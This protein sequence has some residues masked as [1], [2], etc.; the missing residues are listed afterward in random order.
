MPENENAGERIKKTLIE[1]LL[2]ETLGNLSTRLFSHQNIFEGLFVKLAQYDEVIEQDIKIAKE[3]ARAKF[4]NKETTF[5]EGMYPTAYEITGSHFDV[6]YS[7]DSKQRAIIFR[8]NIDLY[9]VSEGDRYID[10]G[11]YSEPKEKKIADVMALERGDFNSDISRING[12][13][14]LDIAK[15]I[16]DNILDRISLE[17]IRRGKK[18]LRKLNLFGNK[19]TGISRSDANRFLKHHSPQSWKELSKVE[20]A[21]HNYVKNIVSLAQ[22][23]LSKSQEISKNKRW[24]I[25]SNLSIS[26]YGNAISFGWIENKDYLKLF[27]DKFDK[28]YFTQRLNKI[29]SNVDGI[30]Y[31]LKRKIRDILKS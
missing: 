17:I 24:K 9:V 12:L 25:V 14:D 6:C 31:K 23:A 3:K 13:E 10:E 1:L 28:E 2:D 19:D 5:H 18:N 21:S 15:P 26:A 20:E 4:E 7:H 16:R 27:E 11:E 22:L 8:K 30:G 29:L